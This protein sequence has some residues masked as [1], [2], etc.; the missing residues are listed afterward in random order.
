[1]ARAQKK[2]SDEG[3]PIVGVD[4]AGLYL[5]PLAVRTWALRGQTPV[6]PVKLT[7]EHLSAISGSTLD[8]RLFLQMRE[9]AY[10]SA[11]VVGFLRV[12]VRKIRG[13][14][15]LIRLAHP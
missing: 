7:H 15:L 8:G 10:D 13:R 9:A 3:R 2:A 6:L 1:L 5:L 12:L 4:E 11:G 14:L